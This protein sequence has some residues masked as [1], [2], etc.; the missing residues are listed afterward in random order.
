VGR[1]TWG[2]KKRGDGEL[3][4]RLDQRSFLVFKKLSIGKRGRKEKLLT[5]EGEKEV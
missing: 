1:D 5:H 4:L 2:G 3:P